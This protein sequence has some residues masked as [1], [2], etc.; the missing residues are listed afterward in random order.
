MVES[1]PERGAENEPFPQRTGSVEVIAGS[2]FSGKTDEL[3]R[4]LRRAKIARQKIQVFK[5]IIDVRY[6][7]ENLASHSGSEFEATPVNNVNE[8][9]GLLEEDTNVVAIDEAQFFDDEIAP[10]VQELANKNVRVIVAGLEMD[11]RGEPFGPMPLLL[12]QAD[13]VD[14]FEAICMVCG[15]AATRTQRLVDGKPAHFDDPIVVVGA[16]E[17]YEAR[18]REHHEVKLPRV[19]VKRAE[20]VS[21]AER[22]NAIESYNAAISQARK[23]AELV[24]DEFIESKSFSGL[25]SLVRKEHEAILS[26]FSIDSSAITT[27]V[28]DVI[29][30]RWEGGNRLIIEEARELGIEPHPNYIGDRVQAESC[31]RQLLANEQ[32]RN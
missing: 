16:S 29:Q 9:R 30:E 25:V 12:A 7:K 21:E 2:M 27:Y 22:L 1:L 8:I 28:T 15:E 23:I 31:L 3:I 10:F 17:L 5:P 32:N 19:S 6:S 4:R 20:V 11:F 24:V 26:Q 13:K 18:C 14:K